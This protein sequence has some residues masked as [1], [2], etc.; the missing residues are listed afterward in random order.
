M[1]MTRIDT[2]DIP[3]KETKEPSPKGSSNSF[4]AI[5][6]SAMKEADQLSPLQLKKM[7]PKLAVIAFFFLVHDFFF[8]LISFLCFVSVV[9]RHHSRCCLVHWILLPNWDSIW[10]LQCG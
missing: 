3:D 10:K 4:Y 8:H 7:T 1:E 6:E 2:E 5:Y 9:D